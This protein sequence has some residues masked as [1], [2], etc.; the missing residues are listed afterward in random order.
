MTRCPTAP[1]VVEGVRSTGTGSRR[2]SSSAGSPSTTRCRS[3]YPY[4]LA[5]PLQTALMARR[6]F[7]LPLPGLVHLE[8]RVATHRRLDAEDPL[9]CR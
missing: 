5:F 2:T 6:D 3:T 1:C 9:T 4:V 7:P 8:N